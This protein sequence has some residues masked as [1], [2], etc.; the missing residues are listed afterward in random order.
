L[1][2]EPISKDIM[3]M[4]ENIHSALA[5]KRANFLAI[6]VG[7]VEIYVL[8]IPARLPGSNFQ[9]SGRKKAFW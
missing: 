2:L 8:A 9:N 6:C 3:V 7:Y 5:V 4:I 1:F